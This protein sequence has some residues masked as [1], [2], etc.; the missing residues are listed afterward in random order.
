MPSPSPQDKQ[1]VKD[2]IFAFYTVGG[3]PA[4]N[5]ANYNDQVAKIFGEMLLE[6]Q[7]CTS[8]IVLVPHHTIGKPTIIW[9][10]QNIKRSVIESMSKDVSMSCIRETARRWYTPLR[11]AGLGI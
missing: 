10:A 1:K 5:L 11:M 4:P 7:S 2:Q 3:M 6:A 8:K 9:L